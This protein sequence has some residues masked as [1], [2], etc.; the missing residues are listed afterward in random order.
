MKHDVRKLFEDR[1]ESTFN[2][3]KDHYE[4]GPRGTYKIDLIQHKWEGFNACYEILEK[5]LAEE[6]AKSQKLVYALEYYDNHESVIKEAYHTG[7]G[8]QIAVVH[9]FINHVAT[10]ALREYRGEK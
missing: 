7:V 9:T 1:Y 6:K 2:L 8:N 4:R 5:E 3:L 10:E